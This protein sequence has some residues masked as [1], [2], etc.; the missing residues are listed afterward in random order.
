MGYRKLTEVE[1]SNKSV[2]LRLDLNAPIENGFVTNK[3]RIYRSIPTI[4]HII[5]KD[6]S[7]I[8]M[9][10]L[11][12]PEENNEFQPKYSLKPVVKVLEEILERDIPLYSLEELEK[13]SQ[14]PTISILENSRFYV[15]EK[16]ND[17]GLSNRLSDLADLFVMDAFA[18]SHRA[19]ASTTGVIHF[20]KE[21]CA[22]L[23]LDEELTALTKVK[24]N[25]DHSV[26][27]L[28]LIHI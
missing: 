22:G 15:G 11:G 18:T 2:L 12:R 3:E 27:I 6:C 4:A 28:S 16:D 10:H 9:S 25:A 26:A 8:L 24:K 17:V 14:R 20:S 1:L 19:H 5:N 21:A 7:L 23:L 13:L